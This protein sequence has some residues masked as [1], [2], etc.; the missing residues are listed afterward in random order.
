MANNNKKKKNKKRKTH[1]KLV[2]ESLL[3][4]ISGKKVVEV[5]I[6]KEDLKRLEH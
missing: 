2:T 1:T 6:Q 5:L 3:K 4:S